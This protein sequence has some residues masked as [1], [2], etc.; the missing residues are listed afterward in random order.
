MAFASLANMDIGYDVD[1]ELSMNDP[2]APF[3]TVS[4]HPTTLGATTRAG[5]RD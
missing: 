3:G 1:A 2:F 4:H 5:P